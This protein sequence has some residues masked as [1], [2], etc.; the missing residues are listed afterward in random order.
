V[1]ILT[2]PL[3]WSMGLQ[4]PHLIGAQLSQQDFRDPLLN[5]QIRFF[6][7]IWFGVGLLLILW[8]LD[9]ARYAIILP[10]TLGMVFIAGIGRTASIVQFG[11]PANAQGMAFVIVTTTL[12]IVGMPLMLWWYWRLT[13]SAS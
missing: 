9:S 8:L 13:R 10:G 11:L 6:G 2:G 5:S 7:A 3:D 12:E 4:A 1:P